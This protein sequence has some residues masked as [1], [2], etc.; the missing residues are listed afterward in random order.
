MLKRC[1]LQL[2]PCHLVYVLS[3]TFFPQ[4]GQS[5]LGLLV[6][7]IAT[8]L[9]IRNSV[10]SFVRPL[11]QVLL[12]TFS[13]FIRLDL[14]SSSTLDRFIGP[15]C[16]PLFHGIEFRPVE[17]SPPSVRFSSMPRFKSDLPHQRINRRSIAN[18]PNSVRF[19]S[20]ITM[21]DL[22]LGVCTRSPLLW[23]HARLS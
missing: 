19:R 23:A 13:F 16:I 17:P 1:D 5:I 8:D 2:S 9:A 21:F 12:F 10:F 4:L 14:R 22:F 15:V 6:W 7:I 20:N 11:Y 3:D 18:D